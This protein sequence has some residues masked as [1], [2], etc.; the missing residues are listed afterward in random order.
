MKPRPPETRDQPVVGIALMLVAVLSFTV[1]DTI[2]KLLVETY[3]VPMVVWARYA[4]NLLLMLAFVPR[5]GMGLVRT[6][7]LGIQVLRGLMLVGATASMFAAVRFLPLA[8]VYAISFVS[9]LLVALFAVPLLRENV[10]P[11]Q[12]A[13]ILLGFVGVVIALKP[14]FSA[15]DWT[16]LLPLSMASFYALYQIL[17]RF[18]GAREDP[19]TTLFYT[20]LVGTVAMTAVLPL[21]WDRPTKGAWATMAAMGAVGLVGQ[22]CLIR[23]FTFAK[24]SLLSPLVYTQ[25]V[26]AAVIGF[27]VFNT[28]PSAATLAGAAIVAGSGAILLRRRQPAPIDREASQ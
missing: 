25:I 19:L 2:A 3:E 13:A 26:W 21:F 15:F 20:A 14:S 4:F 18:V 23:A 9:P 6:D 17:T 24:A 1:L 28:A 5:K 12:W 16:T 22:L 7:R 8:D 11:S 10:E 27:V